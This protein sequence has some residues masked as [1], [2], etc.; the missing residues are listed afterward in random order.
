MPGGAVEGARHGSARCTVCHRL[1]ESS[2]R[3]LPV[4]TLQRES[5]TGS[6]FCALRLFDSVNQAIGLGDGQWARN[7]YR[8]LH[9]PKTVVLPAY[10]KSAITR[11]DNVKRSTAD[12]KIG[13]EDARDAPMT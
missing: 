9:I 5:S 1:N 11:R 10:A 12:L 3:Y 7:I 8:G 6:A 2:L 13:L 4:Q